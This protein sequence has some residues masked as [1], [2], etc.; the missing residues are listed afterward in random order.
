MSN[1]RQLIKC[2]EGSSIHQE[3]VSPQTLP[4]QKKT[5]LTTVPSPHPS[6]AMTEKARVSSRVTVAEQWLQF[7]SIDVLSSFSQAKARKVN[8][9]TKDQRQAIVFTSFRS[10]AV[11]REGDLF[12]Q[13]P[14][15]V[16]QI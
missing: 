1:A 8:W 9:V 4:N 5:V 15:L 14:S 16:L 11:S 12:P 6:T 2:L 10:L 7:T 13:V 3:N